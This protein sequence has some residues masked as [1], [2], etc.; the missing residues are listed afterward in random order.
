[1]RKKEKHIKTQ[2]NQGLISENQE[3]RQNLSK[4]ETERQHSI[5]GNQK[6][7]ES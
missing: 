1:M 5:Q 7:Q 4:L 2:C 6:L 3:E